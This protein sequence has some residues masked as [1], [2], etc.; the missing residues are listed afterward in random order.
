MS[1]D[2]VTFDEIQVG[3]TLEIG[4]MDDDYGFVMFETV[5]IAER[6]DDR[7]RAH[8]HMLNTEIHFG[9]SEFQELMDRNLVV[10]KTEN[11]D[12]D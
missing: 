6:C 2:M 11:E 1:N 9:E 3:D 12:L 7:L 4:A 8:S 10:R 5:T